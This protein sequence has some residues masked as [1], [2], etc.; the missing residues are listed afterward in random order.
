MNRISS[1][2]V[3]NLSNILKKKPEGIHTPY[4]NKQEI[5]FTKSAI[6]SGYVSSVGNFVN[7]FEKLLSNYTGAKYVIAVNTGTSALHL[8]LKCFDIGKGDEVLIP[9]LSFVATGNAVKYCNAT[10]HFIDIEE[11]TLGID[12]SKLENYLSRI[13]KI[14]GS[15]CINKKTKKKIKAIIPVHMFGHPCQIKK[16]KK[17]AKRFNLLLIEDAAEGIG[18]FFCNK[19]V[20][21]FGDIGILSFNGNKTITTGGGGAVMTNNLKYAKKIKHISTTAKKNHPW[22]YNHD[23]LGFNYRMPNLNAA[24]G[25]AQILKI[26]TILKLKIKLARLY[27]QKFKNNKYFD[28]FDEPIRS[29]SNF[30]LQTIVLKNEYSS[31]KETIIKDLNLS[32]FPSRP[33]WSLIHQLSY[34]KNCPKMNLQC[35]INLFNRIINLPSGPDII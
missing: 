30:W 9:S 11:K 3:K 14:V 8:A 24:L 2:I 12:P 13:T 16:L 29:K 25:C 5:I 31:K 10:P 6:D 4:F 18:S 33:A 27:K 7:K 32:G 35:T 21:S 26:N 1:L 23:M 22:N 28:F 17:I 15:E 34:F 19:H 20:G